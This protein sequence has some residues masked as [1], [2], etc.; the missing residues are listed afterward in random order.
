MSSIESQLVPSGSDDLNRSCDKRAS[1]TCRCIPVAKTSALI[2]LYIQ[3]PS[4]N[5]WSRFMNIAAF[6][7]HPHPLY[8]MPMPRRPTTANAAAVP[9]LPMVPLFEGDSDNDADQPAV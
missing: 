6:L 7:T 1:V 3:T 8:Y 4:I 9:A 5:V 2:K